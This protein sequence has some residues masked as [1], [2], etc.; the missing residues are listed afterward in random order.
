MRVVHTPGVECPRPLRTSRRWE[1]PRREPELA[2]SLQG[3]DRKIARL[4]ER[5]PGVPC[6]SVGSY[7]A[8]CSPEAKGS[9]ALA[10]VKSR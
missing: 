6:S 5:S 4:A 7:K 1:T 3:G 2:R 8:G 9:R 10:S